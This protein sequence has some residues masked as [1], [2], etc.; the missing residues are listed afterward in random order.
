MPLPS[1]D[2]LMIS[3]RQ[4]EVLG[5]WGVATNHAVDQATLGA[6]L[7]GLMAEEADAPV[8]LDE[9]ID[10]LGAGAEPLERLLGDAIALAEV[11]ERA[12]RRDDRWPHGLTD[13]LRDIA[14]LLEMHQ[15]REPVAYAAALEAGAGG[16]PLVRRM[17]AEHRCI[18]RRFAAITEMTGDL[19]APP[20]AC[21]TWRLLYVLCTK[22]GCDIERR[23]ATEE[24]RIYA[25]RLRNRT[26]A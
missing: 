2:H 22:I 25:P 1:R 11:G 21:A 6:A 20:H 13:A 3:P 12:H 4:A 14:D 24:R 7:S 8:G 19:D 23:M 10:Q 17:V 5:R 16:A 18:R 26:E 15:A 9:L